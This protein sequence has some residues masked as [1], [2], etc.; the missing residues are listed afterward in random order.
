MVP[1]HIK[2][3]KLYG[4]ER[5][6]SLITD[7]FCR[8]SEG[9]N[10]AFFIGG[11]SGSGKSMLVHSL[12]PRI[13]IAGGFVLEQKV[14]QMSKERPLLDVIS[15]FNK[16]CL[17]IKEKSVEWQLREVSDKLKCEFE[18]DFA[19]LAR[20][21][22][23]IMVIFPDKDDGS[24]INYPRLYHGREDLMLSLQ[25]VC[26][27]LQRFMRIVS[28][29]V[30]PVML[31]LDDIH[32]A[33]STSLHLIRSLLC[34]TKGGCFM[35]VG[36]YRDNE[37][38]SDHPIFD[39]MNN[40]R[41]GGVRSTSV[42]LCGL[43]KQDLNQMIAE[44]LC[45]LPRLCSPLSDILTEKTEGNPYFLLVFLRSLVDRRLLKYS[46]R[47]KKWIWDEG[48]IRSEHITDNVLYLLSSKMTS[49]DEDIQLVLKVIS[50]FGIKCDDR[51][52]EHLS[53]TS[54]YTGIE[55]WINKAV[56]EGYLL[57]GKFRFVHDKV[58]EAAYSLIP[59]REKSRVS[60]LLLCDTLY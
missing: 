51:V 29:K 30:N 53:K 20:L 6:I 54:K 16:L 10:E 2:E 4:R 42:H 23:N 36:S 28:S 11:Y 1:L 7:T 55:D 38:T 50:C 34:D 48:K 39:L 12:T 17:L 9:N 25:N 33:G 18:S 35:F 59:E 3:G 19:V 41:M 58:R 5:E 60:L 13:D 40:I 26:F 27:I 21:L 37:V 24:G 22:P 56:K 8:V 15:A 43:S 32:W 46:L 44:M 14:D 47:E 52:I 45:I 57:Q 49:L 31:F